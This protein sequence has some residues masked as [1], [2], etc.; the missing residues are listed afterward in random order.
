MEIP[1]FISGGLTKVMNFDLVPKNVLIR[2]TKNVSKPPV[3]HLV[4][5]AFDIEIK[6]RKVIGTFLIGQL[7]PQSGIKLSNDLIIPII[8][9]GHN[10]L[11]FLPLT[12]P[13]S[14]CH[15]WISNSFTSFPV[16]VPLMQNRLMFLGK[17]H[18]VVKIHMLKGPEPITIDPSITN[19]QCRVLESDVLE[20][21][22]PSAGSKISDRLIGRSTSHCPVEYQPSDN[23]SV[24]RGEVNL[25]ILATIIITCWLPSLWICR[26]SRPTGRIPGRPT[27]S[28]MRPR[29]LTTLHY[30]LRSSPALGS[31]TRGSF[32]L[33]LLII[34]GVGF[35]N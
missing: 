25:I 9:E 7:D 16:D 4:P 3:A 12:G 5:A 29:G 22:G 2:E 28:T 14:L 26:G 18:R 6:I 19:T 1:G 31:G 27:A 30:V 15:F 32:F 11:H 34:V 23:R 33:N 21:S 17:N 35:N 10:I 13:Q 20:K 8:L 24:G